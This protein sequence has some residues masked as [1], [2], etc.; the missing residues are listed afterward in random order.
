MTSSNISGT[1]EAQ[2]VN[3]DP[4]NKLPYQDEIER[5]ILRRLRRERVEGFTLEMAHEIAA[6]F[7]AL[8][9]DVAALVEKLEKR[10]A[11]YR[12]S[13]PSAEHSAALYDE[14]A[15]L[16]LSQSV[17]LARAR[18]VMAPFVEVADRVH[19]RTEDDRLLDVMTAGARLTI[20]DFR[21]ARAWLSKA[22]GR[23][24]Q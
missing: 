23:S 22:E 14:A 1:E 21:A 13:G 17:A 4:L 3:V 9:Q 2:A 18:E 19:E 16:I 10:A 24:A 15:S 12:Q 11:D 8:P 6:V 20:G 5:I 7:P